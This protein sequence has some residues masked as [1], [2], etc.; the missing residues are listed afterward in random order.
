MIEKEQLLITSDGNPPD[1]CSDYDIES[2]RCKS[3]GQLCD[4]C[5]EN[6]LKNSFLYD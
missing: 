5:Y 3:S 6:S 1:P 2:G 4:A